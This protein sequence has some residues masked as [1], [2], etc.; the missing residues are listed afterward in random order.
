[1]SLRLGQSTDAP[2]LCGQ[3]RRTAAGR[4]P[5]EKWWHPQK[6]LVERGLKGWSGKGWGGGS[7]KGGRKLEHGRVNM[8]SLL[9]HHSGP[10]RSLLWGVVVA[11]GFDGGGA[12]WVGQFSGVGCKA[13]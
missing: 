8:G 5:R 3:R 6:H 2:W 13:D 9:E 12:V 10:P 7:V 1:M 11:A 4:R